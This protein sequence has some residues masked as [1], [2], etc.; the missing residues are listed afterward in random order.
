M[1]CQSIGG[2]GVSSA[3]EEDESFGPK[4]TGM[5]MWYERSK[6]M[7]KAVNE[8]MRCGILSGNANVVDVDVR[9]RQ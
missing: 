5:R 8:V 3:I 4:S 6:A 2:K 1:T 9:K 7:Y